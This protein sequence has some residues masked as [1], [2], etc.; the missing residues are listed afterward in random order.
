M[1]DEPFEVM[2]DLRV[3][4]LIMVRYGTNPFGLALRIHLDDVGSN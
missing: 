1:P 2:G 4:R 3:G